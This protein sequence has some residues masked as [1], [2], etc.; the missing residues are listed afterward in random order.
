MF[1]DNIL[2][3]QRDALDFLLMTM[4]IHFGF[5][6]KSIINSVW[7]KSAKS[8]ISPNRKLNL[9]DLAS[10]CQASLCI[11]LR[12]DASLNRRL[13][14]WFKGA[15][16]IDPGLDCEDQMINWARY[17]YNLNKNI[18]RKVEEVEE[19]EEKENGDGEVEE[20]VNLNLNG[21]GE[22]DFECEKSNC[23]QNEVSSWEKFV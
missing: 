23:H 15:Q 22:L 13:F 4:P 17:L 5:E 18:N 9:N 20:E 10:I 2:L 6:Q 8:K 7:I 14:N 16:P 3:V 12:R 19:N 1:G 11:L 21:D